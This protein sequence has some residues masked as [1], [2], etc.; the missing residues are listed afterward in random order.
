MWLSKRAGASGGAHIRSGDRIPPTKGRYLQAF[1]PG[2]A[3]SALFL[4]DGRSARIVGFS[5]QWA[6]HTHRAPFR[7]GGAVGP[8]ALPAPLGET[9]ASALDRIVAATAL[10]GLASADM[11]VS[12]DGA[13]FHLLEINPRPGATLDVFDHDE[14]SL[15]RLHIEACAGR[16]PAALPSPAEARAAAVVYAERPVQI[17]TLRRPLWTADWPSCDETL[18]AGA[19]VCTALA[20]APTPAEAYA[21][22]TE[23]RAALLASLRD[24]ARSPTNA[25]VPA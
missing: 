18:P 1:V 5:E 11:I 14:T 24:L 22:V 9:I 17:V 8:I 3:V 13:S 16:L 15:L 2:R 25:M 21:R 4:A 20:S 10:T 19:P 12:D 6:D 7:Y 23:R